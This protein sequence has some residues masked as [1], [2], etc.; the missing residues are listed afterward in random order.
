[1]TYLLLLILAHFLA[2]FTF[3]SDQL[4][5]ERHHPDK[6]RRE[7]AIV[8]HVGIHFIISVGF[9]FIGM[10]ISQS[11]NLLLVLMLLIIIIL[12]SVTHYA[13]DSAKYYLD[14]QITSQKM[15]V[16]LFLVDQALHITIIVLPFIYLMEKYSVG[17]VYIFEDVIALIILLYLNTVVAS[18]FLHIVLNKIAPPNSIE[19]TIE[20]EI[21][22]KEDGQEPQI[23][24]VIT[25]SKTSYPESHHK[26][27]RYIGMLERVLI[28]M[29]V[30]SGQ[31][32]GITI[33]L[34]IK[35]ITRFKQF[36]DKRFAEYY[37]IGTL[38]SMIIGLIFGYL[39]RLV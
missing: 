12:I 20:E 39:A 9:V 36:D 5:Q 18:H 24:T 16:V 21:D 19:Q 8:K 28:M 10:L 33:I 15:K 37:L 11:M 2:D 6:K 3:Q 34:A 31:V 30:Y 38:M 29:F 7:N 13:I 32:M 14:Q 22:R 17:Q 25:K 4:I 1:M 27:G 35:S 26:I 23:H